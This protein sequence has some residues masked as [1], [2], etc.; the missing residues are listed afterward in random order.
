MNPFTWFRQWREKRQRLARIR[1]VLDQIAAE[2]EA[3]DFDAFLGYCERK[4][5]GGLR[6]HW[7]AA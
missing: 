3:S 1:K 6:R 5:Q 2:R 7:R 4:R